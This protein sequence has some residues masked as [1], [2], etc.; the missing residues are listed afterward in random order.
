MNGSKSTGRK[1]GIAAVFA[2]ITRRGALP[3]EASINT[4]KITA[5]KI[6]MRERKK[7]RGHERGIYI[8]TR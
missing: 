5:I 8:Q 4:D 3:E 1:V 2:G 6:A 7:K